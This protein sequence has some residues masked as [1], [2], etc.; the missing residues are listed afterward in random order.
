MLLGYCCEESDCAA[1]WNGWEQKAGDGFMR[2]LVPVWD[3][4]CQKTWRPPWQAEAGSPALSLLE[5]SSLSSE[6][7]RHQ[8]DNRGKRNWFFFWTLMPGELV[9]RALS[10]MAWDPPDRAWGCGF[11]M[12]SLIYLLVL[13][14]VF[15][16][17][18]VFFRLGTWNIVGI[19][20]FPINYNS[21]SVSTCIFVHF[22]S[23]CV[24]T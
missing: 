7:F 5:P 16:F 4:K 18:N 3:G 13:E 1:L 19:I 8:L 20:S 24:F 14:D 9:R 10:M 17:L 23:V 2:L 21:F 12:E 11:Q 15:T 6:P 22:S